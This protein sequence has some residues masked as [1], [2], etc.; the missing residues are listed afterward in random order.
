MTPDMVNGP[1]SPSR[2]LKLQTQGRSASTPAAPRSVPNSAQLPQQDP[3]N[4]NYSPVSAVER[5]PS[6]ADVSPVATN[7]RWGPTHPDSPVISDAGHSVDGSQQPQAVTYNNYLIDSNGRHMAF[8]TAASDAALMSSYAASN[9]SPTNNGY[10]PQMSCAQI[11]PAVPSPAFAQFPATPQSFMS[12]SPHHE[13]DHMQHMMQQQQRTPVE[14][15]AMIYGVPS[16]VKE[17]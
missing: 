11:S 10:P 5:S 17:E 13:Q 12:A 2:R 15:Q 3:W 9:P 4:G 1:T 14:A 7:I 16:N 6:L 8:S